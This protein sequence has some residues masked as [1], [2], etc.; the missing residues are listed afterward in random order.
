FSSTASYS[1]VIDTTNPTTNISSSPANPTNQTSATFSF[2]GS[3]PTSNGVSSGVN[4]LEFKLDNGSFT[5]GTSPQT[6][7]SL[8]DGSHTFQVRSVDNA[9][10]TGSAVTFS[11]LIDT[12]APTAAINSTPANPTNQSSATVTFSGADAGSGVNHLEYKLDNG[13]FTPGTSP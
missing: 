2:S 4:H 5:T 1:W 12:S 11:W 6:F 7:N 10:N 9:G 3:D 8:A 13:S